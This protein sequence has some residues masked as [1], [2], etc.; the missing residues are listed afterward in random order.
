MNPTN[1]TSQAR[2][3]IVTSELMEF[4]DNLIADIFEQGYQIVN[5]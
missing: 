4:S 3:K 1:L 2:F 5:P